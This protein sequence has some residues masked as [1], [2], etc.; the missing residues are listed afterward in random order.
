MGD[1]RFRNSFGI[2]LAAPQDV[3]FNSMLNL[4]YAIFRLPRGGGK[5]LLLAFYAMLYAASNPMSRVLITAPSF[6]QAKINFGEVSKLSLVDN[7]QELLLKKPFIASDMCYLQFKNGSVVEASSMNIK[8]TLKVDVVLVNESSSMP[9][10]QLENLMSRA[11]NDDSVKKIFFM[12]TGY[13]DYNYMSKIEAHDCFS[14]LAFGYKTFPEEF[15]DQVNIDEAKKILSANVFD[16]EYN[17]KVLSLVGETK[18]E[19]RSLWAKK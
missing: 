16:M 9:K 11:E 2:D 4:N 8:H 15:Y 3:V 19:E 10:D 17:A 1:I 12:S 13:Y 18:R 6:R 7:V 14:T 5:D